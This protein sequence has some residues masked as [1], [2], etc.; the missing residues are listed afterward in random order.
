M[1]RHSMIHSPRMHQDDGQSKPHALIIF[2]LSERHPQPAEAC[3]PRPSSWEAVM[4]VY[5][6][7]GRRDW[8]LS[9]MTVAPVPPS[10][11]RTC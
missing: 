3:S 2:T 5:L 9:L 4:Y 6:A 10:V 8:G 7:T 1:P 11:A